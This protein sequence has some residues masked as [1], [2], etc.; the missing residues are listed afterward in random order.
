MDK[1]EPKIKTEA[2]QI[3]ELKSDNQNVSYTWLL[4]DKEIR[5]SLKVIGLDSVS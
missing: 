5:G 2:K 1:T 3:R 4:K